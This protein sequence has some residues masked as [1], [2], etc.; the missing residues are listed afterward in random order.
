VQAS[1][2][3][4]TLLFAPDINL[5]TWINK[6]LGIDMKLWN[7][8]CI[9]HHN[10]SLDNLKELLA[11]FPNA[12]VLAHPECPTILLEYANFVGSTSAIISRAK[13]SEKQ[14]F[15]VLTEQGVL[16]KLQTDSPNKHFHFVAGKNMIGDN[17]CINMKRHT[18]DKVI[19][20]LETLSPQIKMDE[21]TRQAALKPLALMLT[22][23]Q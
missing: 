15:I 16:H 19:T 17:I 12:E 1:P 22:L 5:G 13:N 9:V 11:Q 18:L 14:D 7:G 6:T 2:K 8:H 4:A 3:N 10:Y 20:A 23:S 21:A